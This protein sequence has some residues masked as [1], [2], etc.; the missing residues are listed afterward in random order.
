M[1]D[2]RGLPQKRTIEFSKGSQKN[3][4]VSHQ[5]KEDISVMAINDTNTIKT[6]S[7][8]GHQASDEVKNI[9]Y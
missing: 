8:G 3:S 5:D 4:V 2:Y 9:F 1:L 6:V 7:I